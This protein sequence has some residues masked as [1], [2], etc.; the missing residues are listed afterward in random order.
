MTRCFFI[1]DLHGHIDRYEKLIAEIRCNPPELV[2]FG[3]DL[4]PHG[5]RRQ[6][7]DDFTEVLRNLRL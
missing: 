4:L 5:M 6:I 3:G 1:S 2:F 7:H